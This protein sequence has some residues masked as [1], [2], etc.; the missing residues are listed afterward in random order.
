[1]YVIPAIDIRKGRCVRLVQGDLRD[2]TV[3]SQE[4]VSVA[5]LWKLKG[6][7]RLHVID[8]DGAFSGKLANLD[9]VKD[10]IKATD[11]KVQVGGG[12]RDLKTIEK[13]LSIGVDFVIL[14]TSAVQN[15]DFVKD[16]VKEYGKSIIAGID[17]KKGF[18]AIKGWKQV[19][20]VN[21]VDLAKEM[22]ELGVGQIIF[23]DIQRD[24]M[25]EGPN[26]KSTKE[27]SKAVKVPVII[28]GGMSGYKDIEHAKRL[29]KYGI[30]SVIIGKALY[31]GKI[32]LKQ[33]IK[34]AKEPL[35][36]RARKKK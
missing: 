24:G 32:D 22:V 5:K 23:T 36:P 4:P 9:Y 35:L 2:E 3:Y 11:L 8:L 6:A 7:K 21:A 12:I 13:V 33:A 26:F 15:K 1:M 14:G 34:I 27:L 30:T 18:V 17:A 31:T 10:I 29:E 25:L 16:A 28:S 20:K 19:T